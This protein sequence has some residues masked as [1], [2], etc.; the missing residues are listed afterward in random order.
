[1][2]LQCTDNHRCHF[3]PGHLLVCGGSAHIHISIHKTCIVRKSKQCSNRFQCFSPGKYLLRME[4][5]VR[6]CAHNT[7]GCHTVNAGKFLCTSQVSTVVYIISLLCQGVTILRNGNTGYRHLGLVI[8][9]STGVNLSS[10][11]MGH[12]SSTMAQI[13]V[14]LVYI[15]LRR[16]LYHKYRIHTLGIPRRIC[17]VFVCPKHTQ[18]RIIMILYN[19]VCHIASH[20]Q[21]LMIS[22]IFIHLHHCLNILRRRS[23]VILLQ[24]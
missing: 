15:P 12:I 10:T 7:Q 3:Q 4:L 23:C 17:G 22:G 11:F 21:I 24:V 16:S 20:F 18:L 14:N 1:M 5:T 9:Q 8:P 2:V 13:Q 19:F 6:L